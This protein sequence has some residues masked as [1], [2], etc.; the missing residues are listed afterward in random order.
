M[1]K[2]YHFYISDDRTHDTCFVENYF[3]VIYNEL[4][5]RRVTFKE[6][7]VW[8]DGCGGQFKSSISFFWL[9]RLHKRTNI[10]HTW[11]LF[12]RGHG[13]GEHDGVGAC[14]KCALRRHQLNHSASR[15]VN[16][17][18][19]VNWFKDNLSHVSN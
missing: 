13:K 19:V 5:K 18:D 1:I 7:L 9:S 6:H 16:Y 10:Q 12:E 2:E 11:N 15:L 4:L 17:L 8:S 14:V 3:N